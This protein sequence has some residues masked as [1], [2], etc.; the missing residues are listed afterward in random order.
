MC[1]VDHIKLKFD[2]IQQ[3]NKKITIC[4]LTVTYNNDL[5]TK[6]V[7]WLTVSPEY[8]VVVIFGCWCHYNTEMDKQCKIDEWRVLIS[9]NRIQ[10]NSKQYYMWST[11]VAFHHR[12]PVSLCSVCLLLCSH[13]Q[14]LLAEWHL[15]TVISV[16]LRNY[17]LSTLTHEMRSHHHQSTPGHESLLSAS[18]LI[19]VIISVLFFLLSFP[20]YSPHLLHVP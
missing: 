7:V 4:C 14:S 3:W 19:S 15:T 20:S 11:T 9:P 2:I 1:T 18:I 12:H 5:Y 17:L 8:Q 13:G 6:T 16:E 10:N